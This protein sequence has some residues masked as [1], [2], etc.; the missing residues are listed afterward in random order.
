MSASGLLNFF[1]APVKQSG[2]ANAHVSVATLAG[3]DTAEST[4]A[5]RKFASMLKDSSS[6]TSTLR[7]RDTG[8]A[9]E[10]APV[11]SK[12][13]ERVKAKE[14]LSD[15][16]RAT[17][18]EVRATANIDR[19]PLQREVAPKEAADILEQFDAI[20]DLCP[21]L[22]NDPNAQ[23]QLKQSLSEIL[24]TGTPK[25]VEEII[26]SVQEKAPEADLTALEAQLPELAVGTELV[27]AAPEAAP[28]MQAVLAHTAQR[29]LHLFNKALSA[30]AAEEAPTQDAQAEVAVN[31]IN[32]ALLALQAANF[33]VVAQAAQGDEKAV[34]A[35]THEQTVTVVTPLAQTTA[36]S[37]YTTVAAAEVEDVES[38]SIAAPQTLDARIPSLT[39]PK[40][41]P[42]LPE[43]ELP[44]APMPMAQAPAPAKT[45][46][47]VV[48]QLQAMG[49]SLTGIA[50]VKDEVPMQAANSATN[51]VTGLTAI[52]PA[53]A[54]NGTISSQAIAP[55]AGVLGHGVVNHAP[56]AGQV[57]FA[58]RQASKDGT[59]QIT[60]QLDP[61]EL[62]RIEVKLHMTKD[63]HTQIAFM[64]DRPET[65]DTLSRDARMLEQSLQEAGIKADTSG[66]QFNL[67]QQP[68]PE[69]NLGGNGSH[70]QSSN[71]HTPEAPVRTAS[72]GDAAPAP[73]QH[74]RLN[75]TEGVD[76]HA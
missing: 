27:A 32:P 63:G 25:T 56:V 48:R 38:A 69:S 39:L 51:A 23:K 64:V 40:E 11:R 9:R 47:E 62:G 59:D 72:V 68:Q 66:M 33:P 24:A 15:T 18:A 30:P 7:A 12:P 29:V 46:E 70:R 53:M 61:I 57:S 14:D 55:A 75:V 52:N 74:Y 58:I 10:G 3:Q 20:V 37:S 71:D 76:I 26:A 5:G 60:V 6:D 45:G 31:A 34:A 22:A 44:K 41:K 35:A 43:I 21:D 13:T 36:I 4:A 2:S 1:Q 54:T 49:T 16:P 17:H 19:A 42:A 28:G 67:R 65:F 8:T 50:Q 73:V